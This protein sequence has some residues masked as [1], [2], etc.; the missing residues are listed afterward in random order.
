MN[1]GLDNIILPFKN[2]QLNPNLPLEIYRNLH[3]GEDRKYSIRQNGLV[4][5]HTNQIML[6]DVEFKVS[7]AGQLKVR[8]EK[9]KNVHAKATGLISLKGGMGTTALDKR[10][11]PA[12]ITYDPYR[13]DFFMCKNLT[14]NPVIVSGALVAIFNKDG[15]SAAYIS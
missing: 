5:A 13:D 6:R 14:T 2:R 8:R 3:G 12:K 10:G 9:V 11:L 7:K 4:V 1:I 15:V